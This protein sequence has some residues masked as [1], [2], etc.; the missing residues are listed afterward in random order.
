MLEKRR[1]NRRLFE[2]QLNAAAEKK[3]SAILN[4]L[5]AQKEE[6]LMLTRAKTE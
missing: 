1:E 6:N 3:R 5:I 2:D 4:D